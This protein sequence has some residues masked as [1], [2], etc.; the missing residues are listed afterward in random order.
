MDFKPTWTMQGPLTP[1]GHYSAGMRYAPLRHRYNLP[2]F[3]T[4]VAKHRDR[5][6]WMSWYQF[7][8][9]EIE[10][11]RLDLAHAKDRARSHFGR[12]TKIPNMILKNAWILPPIRRREIIETAF[13]LANGE[14][15]IWDELIG[16]ASDL[17]VDPI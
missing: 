13:Y 17:L 16:A 2:D 15:P 7:E 11:L 4:F 3:D 8:K 1:N 6:A 9:Y 5:C 10:S 12:R 14:G